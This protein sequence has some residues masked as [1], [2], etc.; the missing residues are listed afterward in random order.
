MAQATI[1]TTIPEF[2]PENNT[3]TEWLKL[4][5]GPIKACYDTEQR[6][7]QF[8]TLKLGKY[9]SRI[10]ILTE[11]DTTWD[12]F[13]QLCI[14]TCQPSMGASSALT[15][16]EAL[17]LK[18]DFDDSLQD[19]TRL[20][21]E[22]FPLATKQELQNHIWRQI[23]SMTPANV[24]QL[25]IMHESND[26][27]ANISNLR[28]LVTSHPKPELGHSKIKKDASTQHSVP[29]LNQQQPHRPSPVNRKQEEEENH[30]YEEDQDF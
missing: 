13:K 29:H 30:Y 19:V 4:V 5:E 10:T 7:I 23:F 1:F 25:F 14:E 22:A 11:N 2:K 15:K 21:S 6:Q 3:V 27:K 12:D 9:A 26:Y 20:T 8:T 18:T 24:K 28:K 16:L 17:T